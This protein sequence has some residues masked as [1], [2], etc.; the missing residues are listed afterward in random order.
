MFKK[1]RGIKVPYRQQGLIF[2]TCLTYREQPK[3]VREKIER[4]CRETAGEEYSAALFELL[5]TERSVRSVAVDRAVS[6]SQL[7]KLRK[8]FYEAWKSV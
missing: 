3:C 5:T 8:A 4:L 6:E 1:R 7:Y 2:F